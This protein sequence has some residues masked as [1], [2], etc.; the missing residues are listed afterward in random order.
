MEEVKRC[1]WI[2]FDKKIY[3]DYHDKEWGTPLHD[4]R[5]IFQKLILNGFQ[6]GLSWSMILNKRENFRKAF[7]NFDFRKV[8]RYDKRKVNQLL[9]NKGIIRRR[10]ERNSARLTN[11]SGNLSE[12]SRYSTN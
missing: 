3:R 12:A 7:D 4:D 1:D 8:A 11:T 5:A 9:K 2:S 10:S 6:A